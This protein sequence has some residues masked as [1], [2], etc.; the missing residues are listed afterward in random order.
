[1][2]KA[3]ATLFTNSVQK[4]VILVAQGALFPVAIE[5]VQREALFIAGLVLSGPPAGL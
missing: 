1:L 5:L 4:P 2:G 3:V